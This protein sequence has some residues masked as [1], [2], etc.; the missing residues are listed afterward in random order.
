MKCPHRKLLN[1]DGAQR[2]DCGF[3]SSSKK[4]LK[5]YVASDQ[6]SSSVPR[7]F[8]MIAT[9]CVRLHRK[10]LVYSVGAGL[11]ILAVRVTGIN[12]GQ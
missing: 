12:S 3:D 10:L 1:P 7:D 11:M 5:S 4:V 2:C 8:E 6:Y 9:L